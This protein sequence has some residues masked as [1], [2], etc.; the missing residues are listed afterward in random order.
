MDD[1]LNKL[2]AALASSHAATVT[3]PNSWD[4]VVR[5]IE[6][7]IRVERR[8]TR[9]ASKALEETMEIRYARYRWIRDELEFLHTQLK[10][11]ATL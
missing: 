3:E 11:S 5:P 7:A 8:G 4:K 1:D 9:K 6:R 10:L 2:I